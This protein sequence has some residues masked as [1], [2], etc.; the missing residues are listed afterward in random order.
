MSQIDKR[1][2]LS[3]LQSSSR[4]MIFAPHPDD[5]SLAC[6]ILL[7]DAVRIGAAIRVVYVTDGENNPW[8]QRFLSRQ[9]RLNA[10]DRERWAKLRRREALA[11]LGILGVA[12]ADAQFLSWPDQG[13][14]RLLMSDCAGSLASLRYLIADWCPTDIFVP[15]VADRHPDHSALGVMF[16]LL[17]WGD[18]PCFQRVKHWSY[19]VHGP[20][21]PFLRHALVVP[22]TQSQTEAK[23]RAIGCHKTQ[24]KLSRK[25]FLRYA[26]R[27]EL[28]LDISQH[29]TNV[30]S[31]RETV[32]QP[33]G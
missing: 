14:N 10:V 25:R 27:P 30:D 4:L 12:R 8:P 6:G 2:P 19:I 22:Q 33:I 21:R 16:R 24:L 31:P 29:D 1:E 13:L 20:N 28:F 11:A 15:D 23:R 3:R 18:E 32:V 5:E 26:A 9:W 7:Q 17:F